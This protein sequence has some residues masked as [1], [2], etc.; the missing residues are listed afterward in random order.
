MNTYIRKILSIRK[1]RLKIGIDNMIFS[2]PI[3]FFYSISGL[4]YIEKLFYPHIVKKK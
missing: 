2:I 4:K 3:N 1:K